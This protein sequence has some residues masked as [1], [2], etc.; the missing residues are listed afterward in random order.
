[1]IAQG[2]LNAYSDGARVAKAFNTI[3][4]V[5]MTNP[6]FGDQKASMFMCGDDA[7]AKRAVASLAKS[8]RFEPVDVGPLSQARL[9]EP[10]AIHWISIAYAY[11]HGPNIAF[12]LLLR[13]RATLQ[14]APDTA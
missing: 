1:M 3:G 10:L 8:L 14:V 13:R 12:K 2:R 7:A 9:L 5:H 11:G 6:R 4:A